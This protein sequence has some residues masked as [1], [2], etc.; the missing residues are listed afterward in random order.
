[1]LNFVKMMLINQLQ[2]I[3]LCHVLLSDHIV[4]LFSE[5]RNS[6]DC[7]QLSTVFTCNVE[8]GV[9]FLLNSL[10]DI[11]FYFDVSLIAVD[12]VFATCNCILVPSKFLL[13]GFFICR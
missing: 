9:C 11:A 8:G 6:D 1:M 13:V 3:K 2:R 4:V 5:H 10:L 7:L 12:I